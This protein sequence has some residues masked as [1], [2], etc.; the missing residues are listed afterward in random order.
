M[1]GSEALTVFVLIYSRE[2]LHLLSPALILPVEDDVPALLEVAIVRIEEGGLV[3]HILYGET[4]VHLEGSPIA[5][6]RVAEECTLLEGTAKLRSLLRGKSRGIV[7]VLQLHLTN[8]RTSIIDVEL[9]LTA[10]L[11][12]R[13]IDELASVLQVSIAHIYPPALWVGIVDTEI[14]PSLIADVYEGRDTIL[15]ILRTTDLLQ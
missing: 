4:H 1:Y 3:V 8:I 10:T 7:E 6:Q 11:G 13:S 14:A 2:C 15:L 9:E 12:L 5:G